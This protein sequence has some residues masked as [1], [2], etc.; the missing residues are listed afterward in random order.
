MTPPVESLALVGKRNAEIRFALV[1]P[2]DDQICPITQVCAVVDSINAFVD[3]SPAPLPRS[4][5]P[6]PPLISST[7]HST[8]TTQ[9]AAPF[10]CRAPTPSQ[11]FV[12]CFIGLETTPY[13]VQSAAQ[14]PRLPPSISASCPSTS[15]S[16]WAV[17]Y[18]SLN[19][20]TDLKTYART[21]SS[22][23]SY[24][25]PTLESS[26]SSTRVTPS[27]TTSACRA[28][29]CKIRSFGARHQINSFEITD[30]TF[31]LFGG[32]HATRALKLRLTRER[33]TKSGDLLVAG[34]PR[35]HCK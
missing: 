22:H 30:M 28:S 10:A 11:P 2:E 5:L 18:A 13:A 17:V 27:N 14:A 32:V 9:I 29:L 24:R 20:G 6:P 33:A 35:Q 3:S 21:R 23:A 7:T 1:H 26:A 4:P 16:A 15:G 25:T 12:S 31:V 8:Q 34:N 19:N